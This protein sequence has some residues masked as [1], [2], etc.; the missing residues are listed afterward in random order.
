MM[1]M[2]NLRGAYKTYL[3]IGLG[4]ILALA[5]A[6][7]SLS[8]E[9]PSSSP[10]IASQ[11]GSEVV[12]GEKGIVDTLLQLRA[13][14]LSGTIFSDPAFARLQDFGTQIIPEPIGRPNP[15]APLTTRSTSTAG[16]TG[17]LFAPQRR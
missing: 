2:G 8:G 3:F 17:Q 4:V 5:A 15:F 6:W 7:W 13:V 16:T 9:M 10:L 14:S 1:I 12:P 11:S